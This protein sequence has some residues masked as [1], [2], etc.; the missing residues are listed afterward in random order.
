MRPGIEGIEVVRLARGEPLRL[1]GAAGRHLSV[2]SGAVWITQEGDP[3][4]LVIA[5]GET[6]RF[7]REG[8]A[9]VVPLGGPAQ[10]VLEDAPH[11]APARNLARSVTAWLVRLFR[12]PGRALRTRRTARELH[13]LSDYMLRDVGLR[14][15]Q[16]DCVAK[17]LAC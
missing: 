6:S 16:I 4:D 10:L 14:R 17:Q 3:R 13:G 8:L 11:A 7:D 5:G 1:Q 2:L 12:G 15:D 9:L